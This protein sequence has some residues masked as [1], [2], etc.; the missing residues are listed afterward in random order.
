LR[1]RSRIGLTLGGLLAVAGAA[2]GYVVWRAQQPPDNAPDRLQRDP[3]RPLVVCAGASVT[4]GR[5]SASYVDLLEAR[6]GDRF[7]FAN[8]G[9]NGDLAY[10]LRERLGP[11]VA[12][13]P[14]VVVLQIGT[15]DVNASLDP[16]VARRYQSAKGLPVLPDR[17]FYR[18]S[19][20]GIVQRLRRDTTARIALLSL[21]LFGE[22][23]DS[24]SNARV[25]A[26]GVVIR[27]VAASEAVAYLPLYEAMEATL[28]AQ[29]PGRP[30]AP[31]NVMVGYAMA[32]RFL[33]GRSFD[34]I[35]EGYGYRL[36]SD[37]IH[38]NGRGASV[39]ADVVESYLRGQTDLPSSRKGDSR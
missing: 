16:V 21:P 26:Y 3:A 10:N 9:R 23:L 25:R 34:E 11:I 4:Q 5:M 30:R 12:L 13:R 8:A 2:A 38:L 20:L 19:L 15:N 33:L 18:E 6:L 17:A 31:A 27:D 35:G 1:L 22:D 37:G 32:R 14:S 29:P 39:V 36:L 28:R 24:E 7:Q